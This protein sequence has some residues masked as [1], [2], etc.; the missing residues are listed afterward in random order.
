MFAEKP[1]P[2]KPAKLVAVLVT[3]EDCGPL[4]LSP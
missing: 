3:E 4:V 1:D 2:V